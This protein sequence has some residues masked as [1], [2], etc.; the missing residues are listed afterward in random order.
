MTSLAFKFNI[1]VPATCVFEVKTS[2]VVD[3]STI[4]FIANAI[5][6][7]GPT[8]AFTI[9]SIKYI[10]AFSTVISSLPTE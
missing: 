9:Y 4:P 10:P 7:F 1:A 2:I 6:E 8:V 3:V 5:I